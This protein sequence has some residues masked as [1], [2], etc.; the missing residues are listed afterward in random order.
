[1]EHLA[2]CREALMAGLC[3]PDAAVARGTA[4]AC[5]P[6]HPRMGQHVARRAAHRPAQL[7][8][9]PPAPHA[10]A[11]EGVGALPELQL[12]RTRAAAPFRAGPRHRRGPARTRRRHAAPSGTHAS[13]AGRGHAGHHRESGVHTLR[14]DAAPAAG[15]VVPRTAERARPRHSPRCPARHPRRRPRGALRREAAPR[16]G[17]QPTGIHWRF[18]VSAPAERSTDRCSRPLLWRAGRPPTPEPRP[19]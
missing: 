11:R 4:P 17:H 6:P 12:R 3:R 14:A 9:R 10:R 2:H 19:A 18:A 5:P 8:E 7:P 13:A 15:P 16:S 1:M